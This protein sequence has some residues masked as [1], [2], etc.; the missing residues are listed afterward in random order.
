M[1]DADRAHWDRRYRERSHADPGP[2]DWLEAVFDAVPHTGRALDVASGTG[3]CALWLAARGLDV[4]AVDVSPVGLDLLTE[5]AAEGGLRVETL[6]LD[7]TRD[8][9]PE[10]AF[11]LVC[12]SHYLQRDLF[13]EMRR[14]L[15]PGG[16]LVCELPTERNLERH[17]HPS[18]RFLVGTNELLALAPTEG[19]ELLYYREGWL[20]GSSLARLVARYDGGVR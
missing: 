16:V 15:V 9:L 12:C 8:P 19:R 11:D 6:A 20:D 13:G 10:G 7:L 18:A 5:R 14:R 17:R 4:V 2:P 1:A 3:R